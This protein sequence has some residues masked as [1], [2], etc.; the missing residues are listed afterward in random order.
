MTSFD[1]LVPV[2]VPLMYS[3]VV[4]LCDGELDV[5]YPAEMMNHFAFA[6]F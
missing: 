1:V 5:L 4:H 3:E 6:S 2:G